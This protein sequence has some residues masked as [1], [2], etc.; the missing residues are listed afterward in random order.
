MGYPSNLTNIYTNL[1]YLSTKLLAHI[2]TSH[3]SFKSSLFLSKE[4]SSQSRFSKSMGKRENLGIKL[5]PSYI[6]RYHSRVLRTGQRDLETGMV[7]KRHI[8][9]DG[10]TER[11]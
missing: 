3:G 7:W 8:Q 5:C 11:G 6:W 1:K 9:S 2:Q 10:Q 4:K